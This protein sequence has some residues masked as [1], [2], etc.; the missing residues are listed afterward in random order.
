[1]KMKI[2]NALSTVIFDCCDPSDGDL[3][4][5]DLVGH[6]NIP[7][8]LGACVYLASKMVGSGYDYLL[9]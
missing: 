9:L 8:I 4:H 1:M 2:K 7:K 5:T 3:S 6:L